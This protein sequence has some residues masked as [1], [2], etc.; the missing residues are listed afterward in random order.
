MRKP[1]CLSIVETNKLWEIAIEFLT[2]LD[3]ALIEYNLKFAYIMLKFAKL[4]RLSFNKIK[5]FVFV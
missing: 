5:K 2:R 3:S 1:N 4:E